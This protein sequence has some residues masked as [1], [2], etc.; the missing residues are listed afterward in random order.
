[1]LASRACQTEIKRLQTGYRQ[2]QPSQRHRLGES[3]DWEG[4]ERSFEH[5][6][7]LFGTCIQARH[8]INGLTNL[9]SKIAEQ[10]SSS[11]SRLFLE[12]KHETGRID[13]N[14][15]AS[16]Q[17]TRLDLTR[18]GSARLLF[19]W[20]EIRRLL[21][22]NHAILLPATSWETSHFLFGKQLII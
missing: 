12:R 14:S 6:W 13:L 18:L 15:I 8:G 2:S 19:Y 16:W 1:M 9:I 22:C 11:T 4:G 3:R 5:F 7:R 20:E 21:A 10:S 17:A